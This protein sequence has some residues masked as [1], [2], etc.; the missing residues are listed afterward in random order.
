MGSAFSGR[1]GDA[2]GAARRWQ[3]PRLAAAAQSHVLSDWGAIG[4]WLAVFLAGDVDRAEPMAAA[5]LNLGLQQRHV[6]FVAAGSVATGWVELWQGNVTAAV[7]RLGEGYEVLRSADWSGM[8]VLAAAGLSLATAFAGD[9]DGARSAVAEGRA[10]RRPGL[11]WF[12]ALLEISAAWSRAAGGDVSGAVG[13]LGEVAAS[14]RE[15]GQYAYETHALHG[16]ARLGHAS[17]VA[18]RLATL[19]AVVEGPFVAVAASHAAAIATSDPAG[20]EA[21]SIAFERLRMR[22]LSAEA[23]AMAS[24]C[25]L[26]L[27]ERSRASALS[28][29]CDA[30]LSQCPAAVS[31]VIES[32]HAPP[33]L[34]SRELEIARMAVWG[35]SSRQIAEQLVVSVRTVETHL[36]H[37]YAKL[38]VSGRHDLA[39]ALDMTAGGPAVRT[40]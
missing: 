18:G 5:Y 19:E 11:N 26:A 24:R 38:G 14:A 39:A 21:A 27:G 40:T 6:R 35:R 29:R 32:L 33:A 20:M 30:L 12:D 3:E 10:S 7:R 37:V 16:M 8:A 25:Y 1:V 28:S 22:L 9:V 17:D 36:G 2:L 4:A 23:A 13:Q 34:T 31:P 15:R